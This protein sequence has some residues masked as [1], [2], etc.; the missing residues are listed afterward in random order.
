MTFEL[1]CCGA[2]N[3]IGVDQERIRLTF[4]TDGSREVS[5]YTIELKETISRKTICVLAVD[6]FTAWVPASVLREKTAYEW[7]VSALLS[8]GSSLISQPGSFET[9]LQTWQGQWIGL[10][11]QPGRVLEFQ[12]QVDLTCKPKKARLYICGLGYFQPK[13]NGRR[14]DDSYFI[15]PVTD[16]NT[17]KQLPRGASGHRITYYTYDITALLQ[18]GRNVLNVEVSDGYYS[19]CEKA[20]YEP[21]PDMSFGQSCLIYELHMEDEAGAYRIVSGTDTQVRVTNEIARLYSGDTVDY[22]AEPRAYE[23][24]KCVPAPDGVMTS[25]MSQDDRLAQVLQPVASWKTAE[26][27]V[28]DFGVN[29]T[30]GLRFVAKAQEETTLRIRFAEVLHADGSLNFETG[31]WHAT[32]IQTGQG[33]HIYQ[34]NT[35]HLKKGRNVIAPKFSWHCYRYALIPDTAEISELCSLFIYMDI[36]ADGK[37]TCG[38]PLLEQVN[39]MF[40]HTLRCNMHAG[41]LSD[42]PHRERLP[43]TGDGG[44][45]M[46][47]AC[48]NLDALD[49]YYKWFQDLLDSQQDNGMIPNT[50]PAL[51]GGG[52]YAWGNAICTVTRELFARTGDRT[53]ARRGYDAIQKWL[54]Y[55]ESKRDENFIIWR[56]SHCWL[57][58]DWLAPEVVASNVYYISTVCYLQAAKTAL[59][60]AEILEPEA[61]EKWENLKE[62]IAAGINQVFFDEKRLTYGNG[63]QGENMLAL[64]EG[65]VPERY[66]EPMRKKLEHHYCVET[67]Y[68]FDTGIVLTPVLINYLTDNG[69]RQMAWRIMTAKTYPSY[70]SLMENDT[71]F[72]EHWSKKWPNYYVGEI[73]NSELVKGGGEL[74]HC[75]PM[76]GSVAAW[77]YERVAGLDLTELYKKTVKVMPYFM[78][79]LPW[80]KAEKQTAYGAVSVYWQREEGKYTL[81]VTIPKGLTGQCHFPATCPYLKN[82]AT[83]Q[84]FYPDENGYFHFV[85]S[86]GQWTVTNMEG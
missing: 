72:S 22:T 47:S 52:G 84:V 78:D 61:C 38:E 49:F 59:F 40:L 13:L 7:T 76:Y 79:Q 9:G 36:A 34:G 66:W 81:Q 21:Q 42:C 50:A 18:P 77:L 17:R 3:P 85:L 82:T 32:H 73:G 10:P 15:P 55:Y 63:I 37:F 86:A 43:Y 4:V 60:L 11:A 8:D 54:G 68:H 30:G 12:K 74:S 35:Y 28:Y 58:G 46:K 57:L 1:K 6:G 80:A 23:A 39:D 48:Y 56:N 64:A 62:A 44:L 25:P 83:E 75:H 41:V 53:V 51:G 70:F 67:D 24:A 19:N 31:A 14:L 65:I 2:E 71:T 69:Y 45:V 5:S 29:H 27:T 33:K 26:G 16:Y 20:Y